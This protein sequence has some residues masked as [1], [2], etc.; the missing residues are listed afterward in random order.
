MPWWQAF[1]FGL[2][3]AGGLEFI[4]LMRIGQRPKRQRRAVLRDPYLWIVRTGSVL[5]GGA[6]AVAYSIGPEFDIG[7]VLAVT[8]GAA[9]PTIVG[10]AQDAL[11]LAT[12]R[13][14]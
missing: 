10:R 7:P 2:L 12:V 8:V 4:E 11:P 13:S 6:V 9:W 5:F 1:L 3:G 14:D